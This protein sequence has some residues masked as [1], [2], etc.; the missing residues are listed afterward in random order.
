VRNKNVRLAQ[1]KKRLGSFALQIANHALCHVLNVQRTLS[2]VRIVDLIQGLGVTRGD[3]LEDPLD[4]AKIGF[5][6][7]QHFVDQRAI[8]DDEQMRI[9]NGCILCPNGFRNALLHFQNLHAR[10]N[11]RG[12][13]PSDLVGNLGRRDAVPRNVIEVIAHDMDLGAGH[14]G[15]N[16]CSFKP[17]FLTRAAAHAPARVKQMSNNARDSSWT[18]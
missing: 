15:R 16:A 12:L 4:I 17:D 13:E 6:L 2:K 8:L 10:L 14:S 11:K 7:P 3:F 5:Q 1:G 18:S 9:E